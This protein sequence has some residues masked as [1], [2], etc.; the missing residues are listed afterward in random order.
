MDE[1]III[2]VMGP[3]SGAATADIEV[4]FTVGKSLAEHGYTVLTG[5]RNSGVMEATMKGAKST[6]GL[7]IGILPSENELHQ[8]SFV[9]I[10]I[11][12]GLCSARNNINV[13]TSDL[14]IGIGI[15]LDTTSE[16]TLAIK[17]NKPVILLNQTKKS[18]DFF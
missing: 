13:L 7:T 11:K 15:G 18:V 1:N 14:I 2:G 9:D 5:G 16:I 6:G 12:T 8:S 3:G 10:P 4:D 17:S